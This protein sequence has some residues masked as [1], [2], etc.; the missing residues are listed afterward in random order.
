MKGKKVDA[1]F[2][3]QFIEDCLTNNIVS[4]E[5]ILKSAQ[6]QILEIDN[7]IKEV[8]NLKKKRSKLLDVILTFN[9]NKKDR[10]EDI[11]ILQFYKIKNHDISFL[12][13]NQIKNG[14]ISI[15]DLNSGNYCAS[16]FNFCIKQLIEH[17]VLNLSKDI[18]LKGSMYNLYT[19]QVIHLN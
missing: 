8:E 9:S 4:N 10:K 5:E 11:R 16:D 15:N 12:I 2:L 7:K 1:V 3:S 6:D 13:C 19:S 14:E 17:K 18:L